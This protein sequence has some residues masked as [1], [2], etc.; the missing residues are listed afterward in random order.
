MFRFY[1]IQVTFMRTPLENLDVEHIKV[2]RRMNAMDVAKFRLEL[3]YEEMSEYIAA[4]ASLRVVWGRADNRD[5]FIGYVHSFRPGTDGY[6][7]YT[8]IVAVAACYPMI[9]ESGRTF[10]DVG[11]HNV[12]QQIGDDYRFQVET[13]PHPYVNSQILQK[14]DS[15]WSLLARLGYQWGYVLMSDGV[16]L[17]FRPL[18]DVLE[19]NYRLAIPAKTYSDYSTPG[20][21]ILS[22]ERSF[23]ATES[24]S[25]TNVSFKGVDP[26]TIQPISQRESAAEGLFDEIDVE[27]VVTSDVEGELKTDAVLAE[28]RFPYKAKATMYAPFRRKP[29]DVYRITNDG[30]TETWVVQSI[31]HLVTGDAYQAEVTLGSDGLDHYARAGRS[32]LDVSVLLKRNQR[33]AR[34]VPEIIDSRP[35]YLGTGANAV[36]A[37]QRWKARLMTVPVNDREAS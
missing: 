17:I 35:Y 34:P 3:A 32:R 27:K 23:S 4:G 13:D 8:D 11:I 6:V 21:Q 37:D 24:V 29:L 18:L 36:V 22:F 10:Y 12:A 9:N 30:K 1:P 14:G 28:K 20:A 31:K 16:T 19:E 25:L 33:A 15:D 26:L 2:L 7:R 5:E